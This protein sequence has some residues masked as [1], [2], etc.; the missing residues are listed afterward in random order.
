MKD[1]DENENSSYLQYWDVSNLYCGA[2]SKKLP[3][4][5][6]VWVE[7]ISKFYESFIKTYNE[8]SDKEYFLEMVVQYSKYLHNLPNNLL[9]LF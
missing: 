3:V 5:K 1:Y 8:K 9:F 6:F 2:M 4:E 7:D